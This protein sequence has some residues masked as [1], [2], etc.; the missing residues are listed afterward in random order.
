VVETIASVVESLAVII[1]AI[2]A[3]FGITAWRRE[4]VGRK[5]IDTAEEILEAFYRIRDALAHIRH[6]YASGSEGRTRIRRDGEREDE[7]QLL[8]N[9]YVAIE[10]YQAYKDD[11]ARLR[12]LKYRSLAYWGTKATLPFD[13]LDVIVN[14]VWA[15]ARS[16]PYQWRREFADPSTPEFDKH[17][18]RLNKLEADFW[19]GS[20]DD[21]LTPLA[22]KM[23][24]QAEELCRPVIAGKDKKTH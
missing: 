10:R 11:F 8:D 3:I 1:A 16:L 12:A 9:A 6:P 22:D 2:V 23:V 21:T 19:A 13:T 24:I 17:L 4:H 18:K 20:E 7:S 14:R 5:R 15:A